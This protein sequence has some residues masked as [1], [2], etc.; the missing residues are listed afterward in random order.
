MWASGDL[1]CRWA[2]SI[3]FAQEAARLAGERR[4]HEL[5]VHHHE[6][7][8]NGSLKAGRF[9]GF[10]VGEGEEELPHPG[11]TPPVAVV[12]AEPA[13]W[14]IVAVKQRVEKLLRA[15]RFELHLAEEPVVFIAPL[16]LARSTLLSW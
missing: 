11:I 7:L 8:G 3:D 13:R 16:R 10:I 15:H 4:L 2:C 9:F 12:A 6:R 5:T 1:P 14:A